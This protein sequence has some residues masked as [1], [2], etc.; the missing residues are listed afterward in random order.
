ME[1][2][3]LLLLF[4]GFWA[5]VVSQENLQN[6]SMLPFS[7]HSTSPIAMLPG[8]VDP[9]ESISPW[10]QTP[11][12]ASST[13]L[14]TPELFSFE[15]PADTSR[16]TLVPEPTTSQD[17]YNTEL[18]M[19]VQKLS[20]V[21][22]DPPVTVSNPAT[23]RT[24]ASTSLETFKEASAPPETVT[25]SSTMDKGSYVA[26]TVNSKTSGPP[27][28]MAIGGT[29][30]SS[31]KIST[32]PPTATNTMSPRQGFSGMWL[33][34]MVIALVVIFAVIMVLRLWHQRHKGRSLSRGGILNR[35]M[36]AW[37]GPDRVPDEEATTGSGTGN[38]CSGAL[39]SDG[40]GRRPN[41]SNFFSRWK[42]SQCSLEE[43]KPGKDPNLKGEK[44]PL[45]CSE[46]KAMETP[47]SDKPQVKD[48]AAPQSQ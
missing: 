22:S 2:A 25:T 1:M 30:G 36:D 29:P 43:L 10:R 28:T 48:G 3:L 24:V 12:P 14:G 35:M 40:C 7:L 8:R 18:S 41:L 33:L 32:S 21:L 15:T 16:S 46:D 26:I 5:L 39:K 27:V 37:A 31:T 11:V 6:M 13:P 23:N 45:V 38:K 42:S 34:P 47:T 17:I 4:G 19:L 9:K 44:E 20:D